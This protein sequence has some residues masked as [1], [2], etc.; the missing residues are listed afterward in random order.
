MQ[1]PE[2][3]SAHKQPSNQPFPSVSSSPATRSLYQIVALLP[4]SLA[5][6]VVRP[7]P[8][9]T[10]AAHPTI[11]SASWDF[12]SADAAPVLTISQANTVPMRL[13]IRFGSDLTNPAEDFAPQ[14]WF[15]SEPRAA[16]LAQGPTWT[17]DPQDRSLW[18]LEVVARLPSKRDPHFPLRVSFEL[19]PAVW[20]RASPVCLSALAAPA[21]LVAEIS[22]QTHTSAAALAGDLLAL[23]Q[24][25]ESAESCMTAEAG[26]REEEGSSEA[27]EPVSPRVIE[28]AQSLLDWAC[29]KGL[30]ELG[31]AASDILGRLGRCNYPIRPKHFV[32]K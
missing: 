26:N 22:S 2:A 12:G 17:H 20:D 19:S 15:G 13:R 11:L 32:L 25:V 24:L 1:R 16:S 18:T 23:S 8:A 6:R 7:K 29:R 31:A 4:A 3:C 14:V 27:S 21:A 30:S 5:A 9:A 10:S 28:G